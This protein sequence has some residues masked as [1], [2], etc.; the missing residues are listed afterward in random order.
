VE[1]AAGGGPVPVIE[2]G[3]AVRRLAEAGDLF[4]PLLHL[5]QRLPQFG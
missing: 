5:E 2:A 3:E 4:A 1:T